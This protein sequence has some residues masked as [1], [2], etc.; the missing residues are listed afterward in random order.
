[1]I[2]TTPFDE[3]DFNTVVR[4]G[5]ADTSTLVVGQLLLIGT[6]TYQVIT[7]D[8]FGITAQR[9]RNVIPAGTRIFAA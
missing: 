3:P 6:T 8:Q 1:M 2:I 7:I 9:Q 5:I 4:I